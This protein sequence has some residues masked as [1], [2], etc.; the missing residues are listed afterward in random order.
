MAT[1]QTTPMNN[2]ARAV[3]GLFLLST[4]AY[5]LGSGMIETLL[6]GPDVLHQVAAQRGQLVAGVLLQWVNNA[7]V[8]GIGVLLFP[9][10]KCHSER[11]ALGYVGTR[12]LEC[13]FLSLGGVFTLLLAQAGQAELGALLLAGRTTTYQVAMVAL[14][15]GSLPFCAA[16]Y[17]A[18]LVPRALAALGVLGYAALLVGTLLEVGGFDLHFLHT[19]PGGLFE[20]ILPLWL[21]VKGFG[22]AHTPATDQ[23]AFERVASA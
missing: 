22:S 1:S 2:T 7:A 18:R 13:A 21:I 11:V 20:F 23:Q 16:L 6:A 8:L 15:L 4:V 10:L 9:V 5:M 14:A 17:R 19:V 12:V 3:G